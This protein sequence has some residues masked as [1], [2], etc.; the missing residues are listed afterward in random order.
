MAPVRHRFTANREHRLS[1]L[2][3]H[4]RAV[5]TDTALGVRVARRVA[6]LEPVS[7]AT[8]QGPRLGGGSDRRRSGHRGATRP[9]TYLGWYGRVSTRPFADAL[10][11]G[12]DRSKLQHDN[13][14]TR[15]WT[16]P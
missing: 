10:N 16:G 1:G 4:C 7:R 3:S 12:P 6:D 14:G 9:L 2:S 5:L 15:R 11:P 8:D 13:R